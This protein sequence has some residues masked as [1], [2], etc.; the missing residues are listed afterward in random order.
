[1]LE[2]WLDI[3]SINPNEPKKSWLSKWLPTWNIKTQVNEI[4]SKRDSLEESPDIIVNKILSWEY[5]FISRWVKGRY[6]DRICWYYIYT[7]VLDKDSLEVDVI[8]YSK[9][10]SKLIIKVGS[11]FY[12]VFIPETPEIIE[13]ISRFYPLP[14][15]TE[16]GLW[17]V[18]LVN[19][20]SKL[21]FKK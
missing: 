11:L 9:T 4:L 12:E 7:F 18:S 13:M 17:W 16:D 1:M 19:S 21:N 6:I 8:F 5:K 10:N 14:V 2:K 20:A 3:S 15:Y